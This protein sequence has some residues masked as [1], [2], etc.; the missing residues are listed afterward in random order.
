MNFRKKQIARVMFFS[1]AFLILTVQSLIISVA[2][3]DEDEEEIAYFSITFLVTADNE[4]L[5]KVAQL[6]QNEMWKI[7]IDSRLSIQQAV[8]SRTF[9]NVGHRTFDEG[10]FDA[11]FYGWHDGLSAPSTLL[12]FFHSEKTTHGFGNFFPVVDGLL[13]RRLDQLS[14]TADFE[15]RARLVEIILNQII[16][17]LHP[18]TSIY[19]EEEVFAL[20]SELLG[21][22][23]VQMRLERAEFLDGR[24]SLSFAGPSMPTNFN[25]LFATSYYDILISQQLFDG[26]LGAD[27][28]YNFY[29]LIAQEAP[30]EKSGY[31]RV[32]RRNVDSGEGLLWD[33]KIRP[34]IYWH[35]GYGYSNETVG[36]DDV[37]FTYTQVLNSQVRPSFQNIFQ[38]VFGTIPGLAFEALDNETIRFHLS[39]SVREISALYSRKIRPFDYRT[40]FS[41]RFLDLPS[42][43]SLPILPRHILDP[44]YD[45]TGEGIGLGGPGRTADGSTIP[46][47]NEWRSSSDFNLGLRSGGFPGRAVIG[48]GPYQLDVA[49][50]TSSSLETSAFPLYYKTAV[51]GEHSSKP[52]TIQ[53]DF[54]Y[55]KYEAENR[56]VNGTINILDSGF[57]LVDDLIY[58]Q[59]YPNVQILKKRGWQIHALA[60]NT[61]NPYLADPNVRLAISHLIPRQLIVD[62]VLGGVAH[63]SFAPL[64]EQSPYWSD[65]IP[66]VSYNI[67]KAWDYMEK[68]GYDMSELRDRLGSGGSEQT[69]GSALSLVG[70]VLG[71]L[72]AIPAKRKRKSSKNPQ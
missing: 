1:I 7:G 66:R 24:S 37:I 33:V 67:S 38:R 57:N 45:S 63:P 20:D 17:E 39:E 50:F 52:Q 19:Q 22:D 64:P 51:D 36:I 70:V 23:P 68:A 32:A 16:W 59:S 35:D 15:T 13:D 2:A 25:P 46:D 60:Y 53:F 8:E 34:D 65:Q 43:F 61:F 58:L 69:Q 18:M 9:R 21:F 27:P 72:I 14:T 6:V 48:N 55:D 54:G 31:N 10:G 56:L 26:L 11:F 5:L 62:Y 71:I 30:L 49:N 40:F 41:D 4:D 42:V 47:Y 12:Q 3:Q 44:T 29:P 28:D